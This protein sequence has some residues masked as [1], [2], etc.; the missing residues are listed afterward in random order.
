MQQFFLVDVK[1]KVGKNKKNLKRNIIFFN[2]YI[3]IRTF[4]KYII[5][6]F[7]TALCWPISPLFRCHCKSPNKSPHNRKQ[8]VKLLP[9]TPYEN[10]SQCQPQF[11]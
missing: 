7:L 2:A 4:Y 3:L 10:L 9:Q 5:Y 8:N 6:K 1:L 11:A